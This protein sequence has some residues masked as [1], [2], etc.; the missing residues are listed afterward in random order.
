MYVI[1]K[2]TQSS[3]G[4][5]MIP[6]LERGKH[7]LSPDISLSQKQISKKMFRNEGDMLGD[8]AKV[9]GVPLVDSVQFVH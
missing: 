5:W 6:A 1:L 8:K 4:K 9:K 3:L 7:R 2:R